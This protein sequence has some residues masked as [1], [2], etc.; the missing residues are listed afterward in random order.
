MQHGNVNV[1]VLSC[2]PFYLITI[3]LFVGTRLL[4]VS[5]QLLFHLPYIVWSSFMQ[6]CQS[7]EISSHSYTR[8]LCKFLVNSVLCMVWWWPECRTKLV[9]IVNYWW[10]CCMMYWKNTYERKFDQFMKIRFRASIITSPWSRFLYEKLTVIHVITN[11]AF[12]ACQSKCLLS[13]PQEH[14]TG[15]YHKQI[16]RVYT[17][18]FC[19]FA[20]H[21][22]LISLTSVLISFL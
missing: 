9:T 19:F 2:L 7:D 15:I 4:F 12:F 1:N 18:V 16:Y 21:F 10:C 20:I 3:L 11:F 8:R 13:S 17:S 14:L 22:S 5:I 6:S